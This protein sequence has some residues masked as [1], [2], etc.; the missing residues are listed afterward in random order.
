MKV[1]KLLMV[2]AA[3]LAAAMTW[4][5]E[6]SL[7]L[8]A[9]TPGTSGRAAR[10]KLASSLASTED[11]ALRRVD[12]AAGAAGVGVVSVGDKLSVRLFDDVAVDLVLKQ[13][14]PSPLGGDVFLAEV[15]GYEG[16]QTAVVLRT[17]EGL[18]VDVQDYRNGKVYKVISTD[19]GVT[20]QEVEAKG[21]TC[22][23][24]T[25]TP[26]V[27]ARK[28]S[29][30]ASLSGG[31]VSDSGGKTCVDILVAYDQ[32]A[33]TWA[34]NNGGGITNFAQMSVQKMNTVLANNGLD[35]YFRFR[36]VGVARV[37][38]WSDNLEYALD[39]VLLGNGEWASVQTARDE[40][41]A[42]IVTVLIDTGSDIGTTGLGSSL[43]TMD[44]EWFAD[45]AYNVC[46]IRSVAQSHTMTHEVG[47]NMGCGHS[48]AQATDPG[49]QLYFY[50]AGYYFTAGG[51]K[52]H[53]VMAYGTEGPGG[54]EAPFFSS[55]DS[56][57]K[58]V[59]VGDY[60]HDNSW[61]LYNTYAAVSQWRAEK[62][63]EIGGGGDVPLEPL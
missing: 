36:L 51:E 17:D 6:F 55:P 22:G 4:G 38:D 43:K 27:P 20:V 31:V 29:A 52:Y 11:G 63:S 25:L 59:A 2:T 28:A 5:K 61:T 39:D 37:S 18:T 24:D 33:A 16:L 54:I 3:C 23:C 44:F 7:D 42:D 13:K 8:R 45:Y 58:G 21:G 30:K 10:A 15:S 9:P 49:P 50:S 46:A 40:V 47:H 56:T 41:G 32:N 60:Y 35:A 14:M 12:L 53:T 48:D 62:G 26:P 19:A 34:I 1:K 57:Y